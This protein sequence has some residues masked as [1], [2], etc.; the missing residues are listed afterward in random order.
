MHNESMRRTDTVFSVKRL[1]HQ[2]DVFMVSCDNKWK[3][4]PHLKSVLGSGTLWNFDWACHVVMA[5]VSGEG[6]IDLLPNDVT[7]SYASALSVRSDQNNA[8]YFPCQLSFFSHG[9]ANTSWQTAK[10]F[11]E[12]YVELWSHSFTFI[13]SEYVYNIHFKH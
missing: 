13:I 9:F 7:F 1:H 8:C 5:C 11:F 10:I 4:S 3:F 6:P 2:K 12:I